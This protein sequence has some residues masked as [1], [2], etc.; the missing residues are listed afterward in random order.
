MAVGNPN[1]TRYRGSRDVWGG[2]GVTML[3]LTGPA[4]YDGG[5]DGG[6]LLS[7]VNNTSGSN[8]ALRGIDAVIPAV[9]VSGTYFVM[10]GPSA[11]STDGS[12]S[13]FKLRWFVSATGAEVADGVDL[14]TEQ[15]IITVIGG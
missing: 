14:H 2:H 13:S 4:S 15:T 1:V 5:A 7:G 3:L 11:V 8:T 10:A 12:P 9:S 6:Y